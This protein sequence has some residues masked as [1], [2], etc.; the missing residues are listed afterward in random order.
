MLFNLVHNFVDVRLKRFAEEKHELQAEVQKIT[1]LLN[2]N[3]S[4]GRRSSSINGPGDEHENE[5][6]Q[7]M[8]LARIS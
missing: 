6:A 3:K 1:L 8:T 4:K 7:S 2:D 5:D